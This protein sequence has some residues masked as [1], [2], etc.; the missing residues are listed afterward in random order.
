MTNTVR[1]DLNA[2]EHAWRRNRSFVRLR[3]QKFSFAE[4][5]AGSHISDGNDYAV[6]WVRFGQDNLSFEK[7][8]SEAKEMC[9]LVHSNVVR[10]F[11][12]WYEPPGVRTFFGEVDLKAAVPYH[13]ISVL[14]LYDVTHRSLDELLKDQKE[15]GKK[16]LEGKALPYF[17][18]ILEG[19][20][21][22]HSKDVIHGDLK[23]DNILLH[24][25]QLKICDFGTAKLTREASYVK[26]MNDVGLIFFQ[27]VNGI[28]Q[29]DLL[30]FKYKNTLPAT[31][32]EQT[33]GARNLLSILR[34]KC[35]PTAFE[36]LHSAKLQ[37]GESLLN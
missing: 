8:Q 7:V 16:G 2:L 1:D 3:K 19:L 33:E 20:R 17:I 28:N 27:M 13:Y 11:S 34:A 31:W 10:Y 18:Q 12:T 24:D 32:N 37:R 9:N 25:D 35:P 6:K 26:D 22:L 14:L 23:L 4:R 36:A 21:Y 5:L 30:L 15:N 29:K